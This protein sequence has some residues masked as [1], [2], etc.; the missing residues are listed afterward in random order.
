M[1]VR[2]ICNWG[3]YFEKRLEQHSDPSAV[4]DR[5][6]AKCPKVVQ[7]MTGGDSIAQ[8][9]LKF[10]GGERLHG[11]GME[12]KLSSPFRNAFDILGGESVVN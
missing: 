3:E 1:F 10:E 9:S 8:V 12:M 2:V 11:I 4:L 5:I 7:M 6:A